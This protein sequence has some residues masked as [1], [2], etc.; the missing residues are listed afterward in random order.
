LICIQNNWE[1]QNLLK[2]LPNGFE[3]QIK[4]GAMLSG[5]QKKQ[6]IAIARALYKTLEV[7]LMDE[8]TSQT[9]I[10]NESSD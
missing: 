7:L 5:G 9:L 8:A 3:T 4:N 2:K 10:R 6:R 1:L